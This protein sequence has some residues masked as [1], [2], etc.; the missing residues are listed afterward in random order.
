MEEPR[1]ISTIEDL[2]AYFELVCTDLDKAIKDQVKVDSSMIKPIV[3]KVPS[4]EDTPYIDTYWMRAFVKFSDKLVS[5]MEVA[6]QRKLSEEEERNFQVK[7]YVKKGSNLYEVAMNIADFLN[8][9]GM[10]EVFQGM[11]VGQILSIVVPPVLGI[12]VG[13]CF[14]RRS[15]EKTIRQKIQLEAQIKEKRI[16]AESKREIKGMEVQTL[17]LENQVRTLEVVREMVECSEDAERSLAREILKNPVLPDTFEVDSKSIRKK[18]LTE[19]SKPERK[20]HEKKTVTV[21]GW[22]RA[23]LLSYENPDGNEYEFK[24][25]EFN[26]SKCCFRMDVFTDVQRF[27]INSRFQIHMRFECIE[28]D[29]QLSP[30]GGLFQVLEFKDGE[31]NILDEEKVK[32]LMNAGQEED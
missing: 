24:S 13:Y 17:M 11:S 8:R 14:F 10:V 3:F 26:L 32:N 25:N 28:K 9:S 30:K 23:S 20:R 31:G 19:L 18:D 4:S 2:E 29:G 7:V 1:V 22:F 21:D 15:R 6:A 27:A 12:T 16:E 5:I